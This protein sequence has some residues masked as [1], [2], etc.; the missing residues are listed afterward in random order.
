MAR[1]P[2][3]RTNAALI[4]QLAAVTEEVLP[5]LGSFISWPSPLHRGLHNFS[6]RQTGDR[7]RTVGLNTHQRTPPGNYTDATGRGL[8]AAASKTRDSA[9]FSEQE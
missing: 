9:S 2:A 7:H 1:W 3:V 8:P 4:R 6:F 5:D